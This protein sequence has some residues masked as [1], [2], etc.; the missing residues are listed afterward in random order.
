MQVA[1]G[2]LGGMITDGG[3]RPALHALARS[4]AGVRSVI[5]KLTWVDLTIG[6]VLG[7]PGMTG[8]SAF[9]PT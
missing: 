2:T 4:T 1:K 3:E 5:D 7:G 6:T 9:L 8:A